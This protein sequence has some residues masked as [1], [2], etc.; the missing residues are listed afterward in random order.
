M[1]TIEHKFIGDLKK[2]EQE[3]KFA[4]RSIVG[5]NKLL[6]VG[7]FN[8]S[9]CMVCKKNN[10]EW[11]YGRKA[12]NLWR[13]IPEAI[14][15]KSLKE[16]KK[17]DWIKFCNTNKIVIIDLVK[18]ARS[19]QKLNSFSDKDLESLIS[20]NNSNPI[21]FD[22]KQAFNQCKFDYVIF[23]RKIWDSKLPML[24]KAKEE[25][26]NNLLQ[27][28]SINSIESQIIYC[29]A[30]WGNFKK[31]AE[32]WSNKMR[33]IQNKFLLASLIVLFLVC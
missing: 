27:L 1:N 10:A 22:S 16:H 33:I 32:E 4:N 11:F 8:P 26:I 2:L 19:N 25:L 28:E 15:N 24:K 6:I 31:R 9:A 5:H 29:P 17:E 21:F 14:I 3:K 30:P 7:T 20:R 23:T 18:A 13:Y 12:N